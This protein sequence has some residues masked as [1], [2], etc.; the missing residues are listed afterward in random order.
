MCGREE[1]LPSGSARRSLLRLYRKP[2]DLRASVVE[3]STPELREL[4]AS[5]ATSDW[6]A[7]PFLELPLSSKP[8]TPGFFLLG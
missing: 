8:Q 1:K 4:S 7:D 6:I 5:A 2:R 3:S